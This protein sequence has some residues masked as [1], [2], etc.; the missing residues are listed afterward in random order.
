MYI[1]TA[2][3]KSKAKKMKSKKAG[4]EF[5][6]SDKMADVAVLR[7]FI[8]DGKDISFNGVIINVKDSV[9]GLPHKV[10]NFDD[11]YKYI[12]PKEHLGLDSRTI[13]YN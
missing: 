12:G 7:L 13:I 3:I 1:C 10:N 9:D 5:M 11:F 6:L 4:I 2:K 8:Q